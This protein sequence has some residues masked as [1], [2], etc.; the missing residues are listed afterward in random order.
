MG[1]RCP[2]ASVVAE[3]GSSAGGGNLL[4]GRSERG[5]PSPCG[6]ASG[7]AARD[8]S[9][10]P[11]LRIPAECQQWEMRGKRGE[12]RHRVRFAHG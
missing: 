4:C 8:P 5:P 7:G 1:S 12:M 3:A 10:L 9:P 6:S 11:P 2:V